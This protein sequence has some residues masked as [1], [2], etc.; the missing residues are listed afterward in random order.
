MTSA[1]A[2]VLGAAI[3]GLVGVLVVF[4][5]QRLTGRHEVDTARVA[6]LSEFSAA[7]WTATLLISELA[8]TPIGEKP[9]VEGAARYQDQNDRYNLALA[10]IQLLDTGDVYKAAHRVDSCLIALETEA[11]L[12][13]FDRD[14]WNAKRDQLSNA[15]AEYQRAARVALR[16]PAIPGPDPWLQRSLEQHH[17]NE[18]NP[19][20][21]D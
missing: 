8:R 14:M 17:G 21:V 5:R 7:G 4:V 12:A 16:S 1:S 10:Q 9:N 6:R 3:S 20:T 18:G 11:R 2:V 13:Q 19:T 15:V